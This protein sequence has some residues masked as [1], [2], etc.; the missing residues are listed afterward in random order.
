MK[1]LHNF[2]AVVDKH[3]RHYREYLPMKLQTLEQY[4]TERFLRKPLDFN[5]GRAHFNVF[6]IDELAAT[7]SPAI[8]FDKKN[9]FKI[10]LV[11]G[12]SRIHYA[13]KSF[14]ISNYALLFA[15][16]MIPYNWVPLEPEQRGF[17][18]I[19]SE[20]YFDGFGDLKRYPIFQPGGF[21]VYELA[22][23][24][25][26]GIASVYQ[27]MLEEIHA[28]FNFKNDVLRNLVFQLI[29]KTLKLRPSETIATDPSNASSRIFSLFLDLL[30]KQFPIT[31][32]GQRLA[33]RS[34]SDFAAQ[35]AVHVNHLNKSVKEATS[36]TTSELILQR[37]LKE[38]KILLKHSTWN[39]SEIAYAL[40]FEESTHFNNFF[41]KHLELTPSQFRK[42]QLT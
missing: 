34:A 14:E 6:K 41:K 17:S 37:L 35:L 22:D 11:K 39:I 40:G 10:C 1:F 12:K 38:A 8:S 24:E 21:P 15:N 42:S 25:V 2:I 13:D 7:D 4:Y 32:V 33:F 9:Y 26:E 20:D 16:P 5:N 23:D 29:H 36:K 28:D 3:T 30:E 31:N 27:Q 18:C 19:F